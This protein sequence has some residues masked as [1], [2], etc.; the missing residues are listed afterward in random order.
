M[1]MVVMYTGSVLFPERKG[2]CSSLISGSFSGTKHIAWT[3]GA[4]TAIQNHEMEI[5]TCWGWQNSE[6][7]SASLSLSNHQ[8]SPKR[9]TQTST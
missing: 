5:V 8:D 9:S 1:S 4:G 3:E 2:T 6:M 7:E